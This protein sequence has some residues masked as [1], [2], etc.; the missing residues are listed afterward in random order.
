[1]VTKIYVFSSVVDGSEGPCYAMAEDGHVRGAHWCSHEGFAK[2]DLGMVEGAR[3]DRRDH[4]AE[5]YPDGYEMEFV[6]AKDV[7]AHK[8]LQ[9]AFAANRKLAEEADA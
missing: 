7:D 4:Y 6:P 5:C 8:G 9:A 2:F 3:Q 1:M